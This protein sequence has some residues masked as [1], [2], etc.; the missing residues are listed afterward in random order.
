LAFLDP[1]PD[2]Q[3]QGVTRR[4]RLSWL[5]NSGL[6]YEYKCPKPSESGD[7]QQ[8]ILNQP[9]RRDFS[10]PLAASMASR[11]SIILASVAEMTASKEE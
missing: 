5:T 4:C 7:P 10:T 9:D 6:L 2:P 11:I 3:N 1:H 8:W